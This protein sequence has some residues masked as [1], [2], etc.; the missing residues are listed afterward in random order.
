M[1]VQLNNDIGLNSNRKASVIRLYGCQS[2]RRP[3]SARVR[4]DPVIFL[5]GTLSSSVRLLVCRSISY[6]LKSRVSIHHTEAVPLFFSS[7]F[8]QCY[9][10]T[11]ILWSGTELGQFR[12]NLFPFAKIKHEIYSSSGKLDFKT[13][14]VLQTLKVHAN[15]VTLT[16]LIESLNRRQ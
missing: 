4:L 13:L 14:F 9:A 8:F 5:M 2:A 6:F 12:R 7:S 15:D 10:T 11:E 16:L 3:R 1:L